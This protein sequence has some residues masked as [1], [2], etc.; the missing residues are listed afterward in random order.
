MTTTQEYAKL[1]IAYTLYSTEPAPDP[2]TH[3]ASRPN[4]AYQCAVCTPIDD[5]NGYL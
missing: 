4:G 3:N 1:Y 5:R 2:R